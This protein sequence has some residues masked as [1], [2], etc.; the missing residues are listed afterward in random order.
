M[1]NGLGKSS[2]LRLYKK[3]AF[4]GLAGD[5]RGLSKSDIVTTVSY[6][7]TKFLN[8]VLRTESLGNQ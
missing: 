3:T 7:V 2:A 4:T 5:S 8:R 1:A 6:Q